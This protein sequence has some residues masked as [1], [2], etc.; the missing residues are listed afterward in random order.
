MDA[1]FV[2]DIWFILA[3]IVAVV[4]GLMYLSLYLHGKHMRYLDGRTKDGD[5][6]DEPQ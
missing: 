6:K 4:V 1:L 5:D 3:V 2:F